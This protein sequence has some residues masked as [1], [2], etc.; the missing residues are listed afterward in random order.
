MEGFWGMGSTVSSYSTAK[1]LEVGSPGG[2][3]TKK[4]E[5][6]E[7]LLRRA[8]ADRI[9]D[10][11][12]DQLERA[13]AI[14]RE[15]R[16]HVLALAHA[17]ETNKTLTGDDVEAVLEGREG[18]EVDG[19]AYGDPAFVAELEVYHEAAVSAHQGHGRVMVALPDA[20][21]PSAAAVA[22]TDPSPR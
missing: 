17:L 5:D 1:R 9:E 6:P 18:P 14:L 8:L 22:D 21:E 20:A 7:A 12:A 11:L 3:G 10:Q 2:R 19:R 16:S 13:A 15:N 4:G